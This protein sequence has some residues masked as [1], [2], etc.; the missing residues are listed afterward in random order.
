MGVENFITFMISALLFIMT[1]GLD[2]FFVLNKSIAQGKRSGIQAALGVNV[3][4]LTHTLFAAL[5]ISVLLAKSAF[6]FAAVKYLGA[7]YIIYL[8]GAT[9][10]KKSDLADL[11]ARTE[12]E[13][14]VKSDFWSGFLTNSLNPK[15]ALFF[16]AFFPQ[17]I[18][19]NEMQNPV[20]YVL[21]GITYA[22]IGVVWYIILTLCASIFSSKIKDNPN[23][24]KLLNKIG[25]LAFIAMGIK[26]VLSK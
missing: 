7:A 10:R 25:G 21:L 6:A 5:G 23:A 18:A 19:V 22:I 11:E 12:D 26:I 15:V 3:G 20:P 4:V 16:I 2:T 1:P 24:G 9:F 17:F 13:K 8:G 14:N